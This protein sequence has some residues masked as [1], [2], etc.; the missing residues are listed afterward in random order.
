MEGALTKGIALLGS[1]TSSLVE[2][3]RW[4]IGRKEFA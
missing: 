4:T 1:V 2:L 3:L